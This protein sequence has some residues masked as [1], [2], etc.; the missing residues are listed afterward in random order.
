MRGIK[1]KG[2]GCQ[3]YVKA[4]NMSSDLAAKKRRRIV[5]EVLMRRRKWVRDQSTYV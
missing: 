3:G 5:I 2:S 1:G 4:Y